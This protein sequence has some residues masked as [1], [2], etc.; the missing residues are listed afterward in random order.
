LSVLLSKEIGCTNALEFTAVHE[1]S[2]NNIQS[3]K[4][5]D[6]HNNKVGLKTG[7]NKKS[8]LSI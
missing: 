6:L 8:T 7:Q 4:A 3:E 1:S 2:P 5:M